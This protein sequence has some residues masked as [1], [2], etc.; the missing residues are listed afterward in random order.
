MEVI[1]MSSKTRVITAHVP[2]T[3]AEKVDEVAERLDRSRGWV[4]REA[5]DAWVA[6]EEARHA[7]TLE[8]LADVDAGRTV[9]HDAVKAWV[10]SLR[11]TDPP[12]DS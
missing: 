1:G 10:D 7:M 5:L 3:L 11:A 9:D 8:A 4:M 2:V 6:L 12:A